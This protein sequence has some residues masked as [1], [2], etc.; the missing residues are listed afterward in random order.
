MPGLPA[1][2]MPRIST[3]RGPAW[4]TLT[5]G[6]IMK[7]LVEAGYERWVSVEVFDFSPGAVETGRRSIECLRASLASA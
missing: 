5:F 6:P 3:S 1:I 4:E 2:S 7:A